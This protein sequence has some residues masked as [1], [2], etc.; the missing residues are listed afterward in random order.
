VWLGGGRMIC[1]LSACLS[2]PLTVSIINPF[3]VGC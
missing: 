3:S 2:S 1:N